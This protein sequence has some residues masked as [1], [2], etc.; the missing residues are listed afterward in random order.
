MKSGP[1]DTFRTWDLKG[2]GGS[3]YQRAWD[4]VRGRLSDST[5]SPHPPGARVW[6]L[7]VRGQG[8]AGDRVGAANQGA[9]ALRQVH[10]ARPGRWSLTF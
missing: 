9:A 4:T 7:A 10:G 1:Q 8:L 2:L 5:F 6:M 3:N